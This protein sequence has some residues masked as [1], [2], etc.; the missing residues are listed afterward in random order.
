[1][2]TRKKI[3]RITKEPW[4]LSGA[5]KGLLFPWSLWYDEKRMNPCCRRQEEKCAGRLLQ[6]RRRCFR[7]KRNGWKGTIGN[8]K[9]KKCGGKPEKAEKCGMTLRSR[10]F[11]ACRREGS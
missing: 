9:T 6:K 5:G 3:L 11:P 1:G 4:P 7:V 8:W 10:S 2:K